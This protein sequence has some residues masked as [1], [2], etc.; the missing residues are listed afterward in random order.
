MAALLAEAEQRFPGGSNGNSI[1]QDV[2]ISHGK[3]SRIFDADGKEYVD[4]VMGGGP[5]MLVGQR[6]LAHC[7][8]AVS[9]PFCAVFPPLFCAVWLPGAKTE[10]TGEKW[11]KMGEIWGRNGRETAVAEWR[12]GQGHAH[13]AIIAAVAERMPLGTSY[14]GMSEVIIKHAAVLCE[15]VPCVEQVRYCSSGTESTLFA[16]RAAK[17]K[18]GKPKV[19]KFE[20]GYHGHNDY[21]LMSLTPDAL[22]PFPTPHPGSVGISKLIESE[23]LVAP[24]NDIETTTRIIEAHKD[25]LG[26]V[27][28]EPVQRVLEPRP[29]F[30]QGLREVRP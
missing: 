3:G 22:K 29:E 15:H 5:M 1:Y 7:F 30:L 2:V 21:G 19:L 23:V 24:F 13:P 25:E 16:L 11:R 4:Y 27:L 9:R 20:G 8:S 28:C 17:A 12:W 10:R 14:F 6:H 26:A 18:S